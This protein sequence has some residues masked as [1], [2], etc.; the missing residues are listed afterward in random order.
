MQ[1]PAPDASARGQGG[2]SAVACERRYPA[3]GPHSPVRG[4]TNRVRGRGQSVGLRPT[5]RRLATGE[6]LHA[7]VRNDADALGAAVRG[8]RSVAHQRAAKAL[9][10]PYG[11]LRSPGVP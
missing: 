9:S 8:E 10:A 3:G 11:W 7:E 2:A 4:E 6:G 1:A 5:V